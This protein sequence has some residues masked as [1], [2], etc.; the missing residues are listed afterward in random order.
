MAKHEVDGVYSADPRVHPDATKLDSLTYQEAIERRL[1]V[2][3]WT[4][5][6]LCMDND[7]P[8]LVFDIFDVGSLRRIVQHESVGSLVRSSA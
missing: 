8:I 1:E 5:L 4:A 3:D 7:V 2:M 6:T